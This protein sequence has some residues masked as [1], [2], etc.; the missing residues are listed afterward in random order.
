MTPTLSLTGL[1][2]DELAELL[3][4]PGRPS[5]TRALALL[6]WLWRPDA[7]LSPLPERLEGVSHPVLARL[8]AQIPPADVVEVARQVASDGTIKLLLNASGFPIETVMIP[9]SG[10]TTVCVS[11]QSGC[12][13]DCNFCA[14]AKMGF[15]RN[16]SAGEIVAQVLLARRVAPP[17]RPLR[18]V[19]FMGMGEPLDNLDQVVQAV[20][21]LTTPGG[22]GLSPNHITVSTSGVLP[23]MRLFV[24]RSKASLAL[25]LN[26][27]TEAQRKTVMPIESRWGLPEL[28]AFM[29]EW[30]DRRL[31]FVEY[32]LMGGFNDQPEDARRLVA[33]MEGLNVRVN[34]IPFNPHPGAAYR[35]PD[36]QDVQAFFEILNGAGVR[37]LVRIPRGDDIAAA[38]GQLSRKHA[39]ETGQGPSEPASEPRA[40]EWVT[41]ASAEAASVEWV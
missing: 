13:R 8:K 4:E 21:V 26:G 6:R 33:L 7:D 15:K 37:A 19:V 10:R 41:P 27:T 2:L 1:T 17:D 38:C 36:P 35:R 40:A 28:L 29:R 20:A 24:E 25:S 9:G 34:L 18:N 30:S 5:P 16:L 12:S 14:T 31:F 11:S 3:G 23:R 32:I 39:Q 22:I